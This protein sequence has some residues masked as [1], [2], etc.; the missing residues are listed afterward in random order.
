MT[1]LH[2]SPQSNDREFPRV[3]SHS[4]E[5][6]GPIL[7]NGRHLDLTGRAH[8]PT[9]PPVLRGQL[10]W[11]PSGQTQEGHEHTSDHCID[12]LSVSRTHPARSRNRK[13]V[14]FSWGR[15][16]LRKGF[17]LSGKSPSWCRGMVHI[18]NGGQLG[19]HACSFCQPPVHLHIYTARE[20]TCPVR[21]DSAEGVHPLGNDHAHTCGYRF[22][23]NVF[24]SKLLPR[25]FCLHGCLCL[26]R[27]ERCYGIDR[28]P[29][30]A[31]WP[32]GHGE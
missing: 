4:L 11:K 19:S 8:T 29:L 10:F 9:R 3:G 7:G 23:V 26:P 22:E 18:D 15:V 20:N 13:A 14:L 5:I 32:F 28:V 6:N 12:L 16:V 21:P 30:A 17:P 31:A 27:W 25:L 2:A 1:S 24:T